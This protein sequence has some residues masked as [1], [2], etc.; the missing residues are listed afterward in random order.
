MGRPASHSR[1]ISHTAFGAAAN[2]NRHTELPSAP[3]RMPSRAP[4]RSTTQPM[5]REDTEATPK[6]PAAPTPSSAAPKRR[7]CWSCTPSPPTRN[8]GKTPTVTTAAT[9]ES[10]RGIPTLRCPTTTADITTP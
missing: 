2:P 9:D 3:M 8:T 4:I 7:S 6:N 10:T 1:P 5:P